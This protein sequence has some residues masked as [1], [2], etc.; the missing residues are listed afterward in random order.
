MRYQ[1]KQ[2]SIKRD[3]QRRNTNQRI[4]EKVNFYFF[5]KLEVLIL[6]KENI[7]LKGSFENNNQREIIENIN[8]KVE[9]ILNKLNEK[10]EIVTI[11]ESEDDKKKNEEKEEWEKYF[12]NKEDLIQITKLID[13][14]NFYY[15]F[16]Q[17][18]ILILVQK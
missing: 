13:S 12:E 1:K 15:L 3:W 7:I 2:K 16:Y 9:L 11:I 6:K 4:I 17:I 10:K 18:Y 8:Q 5:I 14:G